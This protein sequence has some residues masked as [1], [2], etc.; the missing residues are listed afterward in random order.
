MELQKNHPDLFKTF[1]V[2]GGSMS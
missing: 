1:V 2:S